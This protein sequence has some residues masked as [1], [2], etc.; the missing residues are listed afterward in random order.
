LTDRER[1]WLRWHLFLK[2][3][4]VDDDVAIRGRYRDATRHALRFVDGLLRT[5]PS[6]R[7]RLLRAF[8]AATAS[9]KLRLI[10]S[11]ANEAGCA[12]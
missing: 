10:G 1:V 7:L 9:D 6:D 3:R 5:R 2:H 8:H 12:T 4:F 11:P